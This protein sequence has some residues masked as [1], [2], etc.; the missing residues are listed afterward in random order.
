M[1]DG[2]LTMK[3]LKADSEQGFFLAEDRN[4]FLE[5]LAIILEETQTQCY[6]W[7]LIPNH[8]LCGA[9]HKKCYVKS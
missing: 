4:S 5:R 7:A 3:L 6:A 1:K 2:G 8:F 9:P